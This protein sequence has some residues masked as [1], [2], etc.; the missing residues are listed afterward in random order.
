[1]Q[2]RMAHSDRLVAERTALLASLEES[3]G[4]EVPV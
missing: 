2:E 4:Q 1:M 3:M